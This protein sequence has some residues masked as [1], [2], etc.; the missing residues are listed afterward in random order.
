ML[1]CVTGVKA[2]DNPPYAVNAEAT[3]LK[4]GSISVSLKIVENK[5]QDVPK[6][7]KT[8]VTTTLSSPRVQLSDGQEAQI[9][10]GHP[11]DETKPGNLDSGIKVD[12]ISV[13]GEDHILAVTTVIEDANV[14]WA[15]VATVPVQARP[16]D[17]QK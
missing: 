10:I 12:L 3:R 16:A 9:S 1:I 17:G 11:R 4:D 8:N 5:M 13:K 2:A 7:G 15:D 14:I 6:V